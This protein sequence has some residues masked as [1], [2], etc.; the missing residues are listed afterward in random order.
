M[1]GP[2]SWNWKVNVE[3]E[4]WNISQHDHW[5]VRRYPTEQPVRQRGNSRTVHT[6]AAALLNTR[7]SVQSFSPWLGVLVNLYSSKKITEDCHR[8]EFAELNFM[9]HIHY[10]RPILVRI[11]WCRSKDVRF[12]VPNLNTMNN[13]RKSDDLIMSTFQFVFSNLDSECDLQLPLF[14]L[15]GTQF[16]QLS[17]NND[18]FVS[19]W[20]LILLTP[21]FLHS[22]PPARIPRLWI[23]TP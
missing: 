10:K 13:E 5:R 9:L 22:T 2:K 3:N 18:T 17:K 19:F 11:S 12:P 16:Q 23:H 20:Q 15:H 7:T 8:L 21:H 4:T 6:S 14:I 1:Q